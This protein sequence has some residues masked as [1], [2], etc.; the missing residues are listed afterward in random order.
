MSN[1]FWIGTA[2]FCNPHPD[3]CEKTPGYKAV[4]TD[5]CGDSS[6]CWTGKKIK[7]EFDN[8]RFKS[9]MN[10]DVFSKANKSQWFG[11]A[12]FCNSDPCDAYKSDMFPIKSDK[13]GDGSCCATGEKWLGIHPQTEAQKRQVQEGKSDCWKL[14]LMQEDTLKAGLKLGSSALETVSKFASA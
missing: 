5:K 13:C 4:D 7:C 12:P 11:T 8:E 2:P 14:R 3:Q 10:N 1:K 9:D 6:C